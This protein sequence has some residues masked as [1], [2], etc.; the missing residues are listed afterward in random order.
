MKNGVKRML[1]HL[2][3]EIL[4]ILLL[5][6]LLKVLRLWS[7]YQRWGRQ[8]KKS[9]PKRGKRRRRKASEFEGLTKKPVC[10][11][12]EG[13]GEPKFEI[14]PIPPLIKQQ[15]GRPR[16]IDTGV[17]YCPFP[18]CRYY[19]WLGRGNIRANGYPNGGQS[20]QLYCVVCQKY[21]AETTG[22]IFYG[23]RTKAETK[24]RAI[25]TLAEGLGVQGVSRVFEVEADTIWGWLVA[26]AEHLE[27]FSNYLIHDL[28]LRQVQ[29]DE[30]YA[31]LREIKIGELE[32]EEAFQRLSRRNCWVWG[33]MDPESKLLLSVEVGPR[34]VQMAQ[35]LIHRVTDKLAPGCVP[36][37]L[38][39]GL[40]AY[41]TAILTH[42]GHWVE[43]PRRGSQGAH[44]KPRWMPLPQLHYAQVVKKRLRRRIVKV[45]KHVVYGTIEGVQAV[46]EPRG[47]QIN[48]A[49]I[50]RIN[51]T[52]RQHVAALGRRTNTL[53]KTDAGLQR[54]CVLAH[55]YYN[56]VLPH[57]SLRLTL[58]P[59]SPVQGQG[60]IKKWQ[61]CTPAMAAGLTNQVWNLREVLSFRVPP[62]PQ[63][64]AV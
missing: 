35:K 49:F 38:S 15:R 37:F 36:V 1:P 29:V 42:F 51:L 40:A 44:P 22:T 28:K 7:E 2:V 21:F 61:D 53:A 32:Q 14:P 4:M 63:E 41:A 13:M 64:L 3:R 19:G 60:P 10:E 50:E 8:A 58:E 12:C 31:V 23:S 46:L 59:P 48:T 24:L 56:F 25:A 5:W 27:M 39:D 57:H 17:H 47:W 62:W 20:R 16:E 54:Q 45:S 52:I 6:Q 34:C 43:R 26:A 33:A 11:M 55:A 18:A 9:G 30:L